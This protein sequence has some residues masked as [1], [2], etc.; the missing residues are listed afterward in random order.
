MR[1]KA[2]IRG[3]CAVTLLGLFGAC[4]APLTT[5]NGPAVP[6]DKPK[7]SAGLPVAKV[8][9]PTPGEV[10][11]GDPDD[12]D[13]AGR[14]PM[15]ER[16]VDGEPTV[17]G[18]APML[19][20]GPDGSYSPPPVVVAPLP[21]VAAPGSFQPGDAVK[22]LPRDCRER[23]YLNVT[24]AAGSEAPKLGALVDKLV[25][26]LGHEKAM[27]AGALKQFRAGGLDPAAVVR[28]I[29]V[30][31]RPDVTVIGFQSSQPVDATALI[32][33]VVVSFGE[34]PGTIERAGSLTVLS[35]ERAGRTTIA[36]IGPNLLMI[37][38]HR[39]D[40]FAAITARAGATNFAGGRYL[41][42]I[43]E[44]D[45]D[46]TVE[47]QSPNIAARGVIHLD[48]SDVPHAQDIAREVQRGANELADELV[49]TPLKLLAP[50]VRAA[51]A[52]V[53][54][55]E[56]VITGSMTRSD[57]SAVVKTLLATSAADLEQFLPW[58]SRSSSASSVPPMAP[59]PPPALGPA[60]MG[61]TPPGSTPPTPR[62]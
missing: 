8:A 36:Q 10:D 26:T 42:A 3:A 2:W 37:A 18:R 31:D 33:K 24:A 1:T 5:G 40:A 12:V 51:R 15:L 6:S 44:R 29:A 7:D 38:D 52:A 13:P 9:P 22:Y 21:A 59:P 60:P 53:S 48:A 14:A 32:Q 27:F 39:D 54:G 43:S 57:L 56:V 50:R 58:S 61:V 47:D 16:G 4:G 46:V 30:C 23:F 25:S 17:A 19:E 20:E 35:P 41:L 28:E 34:D 45:L 62:Y 49:K 11:V 55:N